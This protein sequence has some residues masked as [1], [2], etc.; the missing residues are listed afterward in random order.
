MTCAGVKFLKTGGKIMTQ[1]GG[2]FFELIKEGGKV[3]LKEWRED[4][5][6]MFAGPKLEPA[7]A[8]PVAR[9]PQP[10]NKELPN[11]VFMKNTGKPGAGGGGKPAPK[12]E[13][14]KPPEKVIPTKEMQ[15]ACWNKLK[16][17]GDWIHSPHYSKP[18]LENKKTGQFLQKSIEKWELEAFNKREKHIGIMRPNEPG[19]IRTEF[20]VRGR[21]ME[22]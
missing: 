16:Q 19:T 6:K 2:K 7:L 4:L 14:P 18:T 20:A 5:G 12:P 13:P 9:V 17:S 3:L 21:K 1:V 22:K 8:G 11:A 15:N 10:P